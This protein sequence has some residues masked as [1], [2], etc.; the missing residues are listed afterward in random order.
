[1][2][3]WPLALVLAVVAGFL[4]A[5]CQTTQDKARELAS[6]AQANAPKPLVITKENKDVKVVDTTLL[7][8]QNGDAVVVTLKNEGKDTLVNVPIVV[9]EHAGK[10]SVYRNDE[11][12]L[13]TALNHV[14]VIGPGETV[15]W[16]NDQVN[17]ISKPDSAKVKV[18]IPDEPAPAKLPE[19]SV[20]PPRTQSSSLG[21]KVGGTVTNKSQIDQLKLVLFA[22]A[23]SGG[24]VVAAGRGGVKK[25]KAGDGH[26]YSLF[27]ISNPNGGDVTVTAPPTTFK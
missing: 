27:F 15:D 19:I 9:D 25:L 6:R 4:L 21:P 17:P 10:K 13:E 14:P 3:R 23:R 16:V 2:R 1:L 22:V 18:G 26:A 5:G 8:D 24:T 12:G 7:S 11:A 20:S